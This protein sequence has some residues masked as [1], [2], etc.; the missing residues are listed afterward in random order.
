MA[1]W[2][3][4]WPEIDARTGNGLAKLEAGVRAHVDG[5]AHAQPDI[6]SRGLRQ[7]LERLFVRLFRRYSG[8]AVASFAYLGLVG[9]DLE[10]LRWGL[11]RRRAFPS[12]ERVTA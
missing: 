1:H 8:T 4:L 3:A 6:G 10:H 7:V 5:L 2:H 9:L 11:V 12:L